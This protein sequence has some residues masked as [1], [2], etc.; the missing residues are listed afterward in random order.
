MTTRTVALSSFVF[1][2]SSFTALAPAQTTWQTRNPK[3]PAQP[4]G[5]TIT[6]HPVAPATPDLQYQLLPRALDQTDGNAAIAYGSAIVLIPPDRPTDE[7]DTL[8]SLRNA[9]L[10]QL[11]EAAAAAILTRYANALQELHRA[12]RMDRVD[13]QTGVRFQGFTAFLPQLAPLR[14]LAYVL[15]IGIRLDLK[16]HDFAAAHDKLQTGFALAHLLGQSDALVQSLVAT[17]IAGLMTH[18]L[19]E[20]IGT[21]GAPNLYW[22]LAYLPRNLV[23]LSRAAATEKDNA[24]LSSPQFRQMRDG[25]TTNES[26]RAFTN[27]LHSITQRGDASQN[28]QAE[29]WQQQAFASGYALLLYPIAKQYLIDHGTPAADVEKMPVAAVLGKYFPQSFDESVDKTFRYLNLPPAQALP[30]LTS[31]E[32]T[33]S[34]SGGLDTNL[35]ARL[36]LPSLSRAM[37]LHANTARTLDMLQTLEA[38]RAHAAAHQSLPA[39]LTDLELPIPTDSF[40]NKPFTYIRTDTIP[41]LLAK[42]SATLTSTPPANTLSTPETLQYTL[43]P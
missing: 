10:A 25:I 3:N 29:P 34:Q 2:L 35:L 42:S 21:P 27:S 11:D 6:L 33:F 22:P 26:W 28:P 37:Y 30:G 12:A 31:A 15:V 41:R 9:P 7:P 18:E 19:E 32:K 4:I 36:F 16:H 38:L 13:W 39:Q 8:E 23:D 5:A 24:Y 14:N 17:A 20:W 40:T 1:C 43:T